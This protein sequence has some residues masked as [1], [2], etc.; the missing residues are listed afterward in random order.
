VICVQN[1][2]ELKQHILFVLNAWYVVWQNISNGASNEWCMSQQARLRLKTRIMNKC[3]TN[4][5]N[6]LNQQHYHLCET[7]ICWD[8]VISTQFVSFS[9][10]CISQG[11]VGTYL[12]CGENFRGRFIGNFILFLDVENFWK[13]V[14]V[15][16]SYK[17][18]KKVAP[19]HSLPCIP[20]IQSTSQWKEVVYELLFSYIVST[21]QPP[22]V[23]RI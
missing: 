18:L 3:C 4:I 13:S 9:L 7:L 19:V 23:C 22:T 10:V 6:W 8:V 11:S 16:Q 12:R 14:N 21:Q 5:N 15:W 2:N 1:V 20:L 17:P